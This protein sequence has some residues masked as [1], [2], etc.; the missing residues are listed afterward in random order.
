M[1][2]QYHSSH[3]YISPRNPKRGAMK[4][5]LQVIVC[6]VILIPGFH[7][8]ASSNS[9]ASAGQDKSAI[10]AE[11]ESY[12]PFYN[13]LTGRHLPQ[14]I[15]FGEAYLQKFPRGRF[16][17]YI[18]SIINFARISLNEEKIAQAKE[19]RRLIHASLAKD[20]QLELLLNDVL[21]E[22]A[23][24]NASA[25]NGQTPLMFAADDMNPE[26]IRALLKKGVSIDV[27]EKVHGWTALIYAIW[28]GDEKSVKSLLEYYPDLSI[29]DN[30]GRTA[31][32]HAILT[33]NFEIIV[34]IMGRAMRGVS[35]DRMG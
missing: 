17:D 28:S 7:K 25:E 18:K 27:A 1:T 16:G 22:R 14:I 13:A 31:L 3:V 24:L 12:R 11:N 4:P 10:E 26:T 9:F 5:F 32:D 2:S 15:T 30:E 8:A 23:D 6:A 21:N 29:K 33:A 19:L 35:S 20:S 34:M